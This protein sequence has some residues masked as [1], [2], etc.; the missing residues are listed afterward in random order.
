MK[1]LGATQLLGGILV[2][3]SIIWIFH[4]ISYIDCD[5]DIKEV[6]CMNLYIIYK[7]NMQDII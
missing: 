2:S 3:Y 5:Y 7:G 4:P 6:A 1:K